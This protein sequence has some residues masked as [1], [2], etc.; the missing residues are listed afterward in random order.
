MSYFY[1]KNNQ[2]VVDAN[3]YPYIGETITCPCGDDMDIKYA[4]VAKQTNENMVGETILG[5]LWYATWQQVHYNYSYSIVTYYDVP[6]NICIPH[7][8]YGP[9]ANRI[10]DDDVMYK[11]IINN[12]FKDDKGLTSNG[13]YDLGTISTNGESSGFIGA[14]YL[15]TASYRVTYSQNQPYETS[16]RTIANDNDVGQELIYTYFIVTGASTASEF[17]Q[18]LNQAKDEYDTEEIVEDKKFLLTNNGDGTWTVRNGQ[19]TMTATDSQIASKDVYEGYIT[20]NDQYFS[21]KKNNNTYY[22]ET[23]LKYDLGTQ[24]GTSFSFDN[25]TYNIYYGTVTRSGS[26]YQIQKDTE[27]YYIMYSGQKYY[28]PTVPSDYFNINGTDYST[29]GIMGDTFLTDYKACFYV[30]GDTIYYTPD[31]NSNSNIADYVFYDADEKAY[32]AII[33]SSQFEKWNS[34]SAIFPHF[35]GYFLLNNELSSFSDGTNTYTV[36]SKNG[37]ELYYVHNNITGNIYEVTGVIE[38]NQYYFLT[39][40]NICVPL[41]LNLGSKI[42][43][44]YSY[45][46]KMDPSNSSKR[47]NISSY[48]ANGNGYTV[49]LNDGSQLNLSAFSSGSRL[50]VVQPNRNVFKRNTINILNTNYEVVQHGMYIGGYYDRHHTPIFYDSSNKKHYALSTATEPSSFVTVTL[51]S[52]M[53][54][55]YS[56]LPSSDLQITTT[57]LQTAADGEKYYV[58]TYDNNINRAIDYPISAKVQLD[59][60]YGT[61]KILNYTYEGTSALVNSVRKFTFIDGKQ[62]TISIENGK[63]Y[64][65]FNEEKY[66]LT[67]SSGKAQCTFF[68]FDITPSIL[69][70]DLPFDFIKYHDVT[71]TINNR[72]TIT[73]ENY[74]YSDSNY[75]NVLINQVR[76]GI[77]STYFDAYI[78]G[79]K[80]V[81]YSRSLEQYYWMERN[82]FYFVDGEYRPYFYNNNWWFRWNRKT[83]PLISSVNNN[84]SSWFI[85][86]KYYPEN[87]DLNTECN[88]TFTNTYFVNNGVK[89]NETITLSSMLLIPNKS[90]IL[91]LNDNSEWDSY[92]VTPFYILDRLHY[93]DGISM[94]S[95]GSLTNK[96]YINSVPRTLYFY[97][98]DI[99]SD[100]Y[101]ITK[102]VNGEWYFTDKNGTTYKIPAIIGNNS[103]ITI[104]GNEYTVEGD[105]AYPYFLYTYEN[106]TTSSITIIKN[107]EDIYS[108]TIDDYRRTLTKNSSTGKFNNIVIGDKTYEPETQ[109]YYEAGVEFGEFINSHKEYFIT[110]WRSKN[111]VYDVINP[112]F[113]SYISIKELKGDTNVFNKSWDT[114]CHTDSYFTEAVYTGRREHEVFYAGDDSFAPSSDAYYNAIGDSRS[115]FKPQHDHTLVPK[116]YSITFNKNLGKE[117]FINGDN[118]QINAANTALKSQMQSLQGV[119]CE[120]FSC[121]ILVKENTSYN[122]PSNRYTIDVTS[123]IFTKSFNFGQTYHLLNTYDYIMAH[124]N[125]FSEQLSWLQTTPTQYSF[126]S[127]ESQIY[128]NLNSVTGGV[129]L[130]FTYIVNP[131]RTY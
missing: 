121:V 104:D 56:Y 32:F 36:L 62:Y 87:F 55:S 35:S 128:N 91:I 89:Q 33:P 53:S 99:S 116:I 67:G 98:I 131:K 25:S 13:Y 106:N 7:K 64:F 74:Y 46:C 79:N 22:I 68:K 8:R 103:E 75:S 82:S 18:I 41:T 129:S 28:L 66:Q 119:Q 94:N 69:N 88:A 49:T 110:M 40:N 80:E 113:S 70:Q 93:Y 1:T 105:V 111:W 50:V 108:F 37:N 34:P 85:V 48:V 21:I 2:I 16:I 23:N 58:A 84:V 6:K 117:E 10:D 90:R 11:K 51:P 76:K 19:N 57:T 59:G 52:Q 38:Y 3:N 95:D 126:S 124:S 15:S 14:A 123:S 71:N 92:Q 42:M 24:L 83:I 54:L 127:Q 78:D 61:N 130:H 12:T 30:N 101:N 63:S 122:S 73:N 17:I 39:G 27:G 47:Y 9:T 100:S 97:K 86:M 29:Y 26:T 81:Y 5:N 120:V 43:D 20:Y 114:I 109:Q 112:L 77:I 65:T 44:V 96:I 118:S 102:N 31:N 4:V 45:E 107:D 115:G 125:K 72:T 60:L